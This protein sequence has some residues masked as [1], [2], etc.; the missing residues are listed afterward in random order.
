MQ[1]MLCCVCLPMRCAIH[2]CVL[3]RLQA[4]QRSSALG[5][6]VV[7][8]SNTSRIRLLGG[9]IPEKEELVAKLQVCPWPWLAAGADADC[10][11]SRCVA[12]PGPRLESLHA[13]A[14]AACCSACGVEKGKHLTAQLRPLVLPLLPWPPAPAEP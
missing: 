7:D 8:P 6:Q 11:R 1:G 2:L 14:M 13:S 5:E 10:I 12:L 4:K 9:R 3:L